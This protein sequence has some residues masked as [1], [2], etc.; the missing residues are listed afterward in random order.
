MPFV[1][2]F[3]GW[4]RKD[5]RVRKLGDTVHR[6]MVEAFAIPDEDC[7]QAFS[8]HAAGHQ[9]RITPQFLGIEHSADAVFLQITCAPGRS[10]A[11]KKVL[12]AA[13]ASN[14]QADAGLSPQDLIINLVESSRENWSFGNG[15]AQFTP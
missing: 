14:A 12:Y 2:L 6:A 5:A 7:F 1:H 13:I 11:Q 4:D 10:V 15:I 3:H 8:S 9:L